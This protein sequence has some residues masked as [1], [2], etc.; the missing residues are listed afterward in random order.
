MAGFGPSSKVSAIAD[1]SPVRRIVGPKS[2]ADGATA[3]HEKIPAAAHPAPVA[4]ATGS[5]CMTLTL[6]NFWN[7][8]RIPKNENVAYDAVRLTSHRWDSTG[9]FDT[10]TARYPENQ[11]G[12]TVR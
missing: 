12:H 5:N 7:R 2:C 11:N 1:A 9:S 10:M 3:A 6:T 4:R 8:W